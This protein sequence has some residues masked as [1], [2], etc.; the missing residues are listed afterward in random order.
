[1]SYKTSSVAQVHDAACVGCTVCAN[2]CPSEA[3]TMVDRLAVVD[4]SRCVGCPKCMEACLPYGAISLAPDPDPKTLGLPVADWDHEAV[5]ALCA[6]ARVASF[7][8]IC[9]CT[10][11]TAG[12]V[13][14]AIV[15]GAE[16]PEDLTL[17]TGVRSVCA[18]WCLSGVL[19][20]LEA[21]GVELDRPAKDYRIYTDSV[22]EVAIWT[23]TDEVADK[24]PEHFLHQDRSAVDDGRLEGLVFPA[25]RR[26]PTP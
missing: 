26:R 22:T 12:E 21:H 15:R 7:F 11:T 2:V 16:T 24:Y 10:G 13:A 17:A 3:I 6:Q 8:P 14:A 20:L 25:I 5:E 18:I 4:E 19:R 9:V 23:I 1:M